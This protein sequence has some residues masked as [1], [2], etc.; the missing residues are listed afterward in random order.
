M[1]IS[2]CYVKIVSV[3][4]VINTK[5]RLTQRTASP[6]KALF[7]EEFLSCYLGPYSQRNY[8]HVMARLKSIRITPGQCKMYHNG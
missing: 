3:I 5:K 7:L 6:P 4:K 8:F 2:A 1:E